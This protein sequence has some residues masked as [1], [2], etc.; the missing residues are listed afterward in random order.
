MHVSVL[1][2]LAGTDDQLQDYLA[3]LQG[4]D[5]LRKRISELITNRDELARNRELALFQIEEI[6]RVDPEPGEEESLENELRVLENAEQLVEGAARLA[7]ALYSEGGSVY[8]R[9]A[10]AS[11]KLEQLA[12]FETRFEAHVRDLESALAAI[13]EVA[14]FLRDYPD[15]VEFDPDRIEEVR[16]RLG[17]FEHLKRKYG[18]TIDAVLEHRRHIGD[19]VKTG[20]TLDETIERLQRELEDEERHLGEVAIVLSEKRSGAAPQIQEAVVRELAALGIPDAVFEVSLDRLEDPSG[21]ARGDNGV[22]YSARPSGIDECVFR[23]STNRGE[24]AKALVRVASG[25]EISRVMLA[26]KK[27]LASGDRVPT[28]V[29]DEI[30]TGISGAVAQK[31]GLAM[32]RLSADHQIIA[33]THLPQIAAMANTHYRVRKYDR[34]GRNITAIERLSS[35][36]RTEEVA[37]LLSGAEIS[38]SALRSAEELISMATESM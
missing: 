11:R 32:R 25:G 9:L 28:L 18:G 17:A 26:L 38:E 31:V 29:F 12:R 33:I 36:E 30:D 22:R 3:A 21:W 1:D 19:D 7:Q 2:G 37:T 16:E 20:D 13:G 14:T 27:V 4:V 10:T 34:D 24:P 35:D 8:D 5:T 15:D 6:D 23:I